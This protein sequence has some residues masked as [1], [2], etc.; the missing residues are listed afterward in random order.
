MCGVKSQV[1]WVW[2]QKIVSRIS[3]GVQPTIFCAHIP[4]LLLGTEPNVMQ[5]YSARCLRHTQ[6]MPLGIN[7]QSAQRKREIGC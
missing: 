1:W 6:K 3:N 2:P 5:S 4:P 7:T